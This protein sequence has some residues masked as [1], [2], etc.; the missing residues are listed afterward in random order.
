MQDTFPVPAPM[1]PPTTTTSVSQVGEL[2]HRLSRV[3]ETLDRVEAIA[4]TLTEVSASLLQSAGV[5]GPR[6]PTT[7]EIDDWY[8]GEASRIFQEMEYARQVAEDEESAGYGSGKSRE[9]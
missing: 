3:R 6:E 5:E 9:V 8:A 4:D 2:Q 1:I 7:V